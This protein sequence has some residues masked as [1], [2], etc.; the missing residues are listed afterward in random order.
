[1]SENNGIMRYMSNP[2][3]FTLKKWMAELL[4]AKYVNHDAIIERV[5]SSLVTERDLQEFGRLITDVYE[6]AYL[7]AVNDYKSQF[8]KLGI[9]VNIVP[10]KS[11]KI[12]G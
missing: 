9:N 12:S 8:E 11:S 10:E 7:K 4:K 3:A 5:A 6:A 1:M 2:R